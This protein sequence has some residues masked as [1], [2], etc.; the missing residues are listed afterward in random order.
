MVVH[1]RADEIRVGDLINI[2][3]IPAFINAVRASDRGRIAITGD[4]V[5]GTGARMATYASDAPILAVREA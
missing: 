2:N 4:G 3:G 1:A 5:F